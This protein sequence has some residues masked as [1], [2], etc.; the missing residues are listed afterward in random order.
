MRRRCGPD[1]QIALWD[2]RY[3]SKEA[4]SRARGE[5]MARNRRI[6]SASDLYE[7]LD[8]DA[9]CIILEDY[10]KELGVDAEMVVFNEENATAAIKECDDI[11]RQHL[12]TQEQLREE[13]MEKRARGRMDRKEMIERDR[14]EEQS[15]VVSEGAK[16]KKGKR[17]KKKKKK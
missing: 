5:A 6:P 14:I 16:R 13:Q 9:A 17:K 12:E 11:Y 7:Q 10:Y 2:E 3:T 15:S 1:V 4:A 8:A